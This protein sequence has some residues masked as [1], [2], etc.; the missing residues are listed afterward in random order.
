MSLLYT[1]LIFVFAVAVTITIHEAAH[2]WMADRLGDPTARV[3]KRLSLNPLVHY[4][5]VGTTILLVTAILT[6]L[7]RFPFPFGW[8]KPV[9]FDPYNLKNP[10]KDSALI[11]LS[12]PLSNL[13]FAILLSIALR[14][15][16]G[17][18]SPLNFQNIISFIIVLNVALAVFN[19]IPIHPL[20]GGKILVGLL[21]RTQAREVDLFLNRYGFILL[22]FLI[23]PTFGGVSVFSLIISPLLNLILTILIPGNSII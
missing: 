19:L 10:R 3:K 6:I 17:I 4:D 14:L 20:D 9:P 21:P 16:G 12:G 5:P 1:I 22:L 8:A 11:S 23:F 7:G 13:I 18:F 15:T 2:A